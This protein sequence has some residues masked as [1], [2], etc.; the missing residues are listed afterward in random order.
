[1]IF[2]L[3]ADNTI[4][5]LFYADDT[6][7]FDFFPADTVLI[8]LYV[9]GTV[10]FRV[11]ANDAVMIIFLIFCADDAVIYCSV[12]SWVDSPSGKLVF[13]LSS[14]LFSCSSCRFHTNNGF[15]PETRRPVCFQHLGVIF[16]NPG[17]IFHTYLLMF[18]INS[19]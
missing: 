10:M 13:M 8:R 4:T 12:H 11:Y 19:P 6:S 14:V 5:F 18:I 17:D 15:L 16:T 1:M 7:T 9:D 3:Y 2:C